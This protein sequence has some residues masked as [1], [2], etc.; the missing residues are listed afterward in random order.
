MAERTLDPREIRKRNERRQ[1]FDRM[2]RYRFI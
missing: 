2:R 1:M